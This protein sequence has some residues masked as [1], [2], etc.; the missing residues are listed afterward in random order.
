MITAK[1][2]HAACVMNGKIFVVG[3]L[4]AS[5]AQV[6][7]IECYNPLTDSWSVVDSTEISLYYHSLVA[8]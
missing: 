8:L 6:N 5:K 4:D 3:G 7:T 1:R 2:A